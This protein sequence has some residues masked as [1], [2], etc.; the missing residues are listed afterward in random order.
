MQ[1]R[2]NLLIFLGFYLCFLPIFGQETA[3]L[4]QE[5]DLNLDW[6]EQILQQ[7]DIE[8]LGD[9]AY[10]ELIDELSD[11]VVWS[12]TTD[13]S[14]L[15]GRLK[16][17]VILSSN[18]T[19]SPRAGYRNQTAE[20]Q[21]SN[22]AYLGDPWHH[23]VRYRMQLG[24]HWQAGMN[25]EKDA[26]EAWRH[27]FPAFDSWHAFARA[28][29]IRITSS[30]Q[31]RDAVI[32]HYR[33]RMGCGLLIN[34]GFS[35]GKQ[36]VSRQ[37]MQQR[38]NTITPFASNAEYGYMQGAALDLRIGEHFSILPYF[39]ARQI[40]GS[41]NNER[42]VLTALQKDGYHRTQTEDSHR[43]AA[44]EIVSGARI[45]WRGEW[46]DLGIHGTF[47][48]L[49]YDY[50]RNNL[51][52]NANYFRG[53]QL[54]QFSA[55]YTARALGGLLRGEFAIDD[56]GAFANL[57]ALQYKLTDNWT[58]TLLYRYY[59]LEYR[60]LHASTLGE[61]S[62]TQG[63][64]GV[65]LNLDGQVSAH[66]QLQGMFDWFMFGQPQYGIR[67]SNSQGLE[68]ALRLLYS[69]RKVS[70]YLGY[71]IKKKSNYFRH[72]LDGMLNI[73]PNASFTS[74]T[75]FRA[76]IYN[77]E[78]DGIAST[79]FGYAVSQ[80]FAWNCKHWKHC[81]FSLVGQASYFRTD[82]YDSRVYLTEKTIL[83]G[84]GLPM[85]YGEGLRYSVTGTIKIG[86]HINVDLKWAMTNYANRASISSG[87]QEIEGNNQQDLWLQLRLKI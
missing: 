83:Y 50:M 29:D 1:K 70:G 77:K 45:G 65:T 20:R 56:K 26:G 41:Y 84:F 87:L 46:Y 72:S 64:Q 73:Q 48:Q 82:D 57:T 25:V 40:D 54:A 79:S 6:Q 61:N 34:Q 12:D 71:R 52:Y 2:S 81:P 67:D 36:Y 14:L 69:H 53:H 11:L 60:Q 13:F 9:A 47:T 68:G 78:E 42:H 27:Q 15:K 80:S 22:K 63:E 86:P 35:L 7:I 43:N 39:S 59:G 28:K 24:R 17:N 16:Q 51:Y 18:R 19:L 32:G 85:L 76:R 3:I 23:S 8:S 75:Q 62:E 4:D 31:L 55:D 30:I 49:Q 21:A 74:K 10:G 33:L 5:K 66:W 44:W 37:L 38:S 58:S